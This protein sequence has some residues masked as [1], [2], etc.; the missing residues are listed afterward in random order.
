VGCPEALAKV[1]AALSALEEGA[2]LELVREALEAGCSALEVIEGG[3][4]PGMREV[5][6]KFERG[7][8]FLPELMISADIFTR[9]VSLLQPLLERGAAQAR[10]GRVVIGTVKGDIHDLGKNLVATML[11]VDGFEVID[12]GVDVPPEKFVEA[13]E[14]YEPD[15][16]G[17][18]AL[19]TTTMIEMRNVID[20]L[21][22]AGLRDRVRVI[23]GGAPVTEEFAREVGADAYAKDAVEAV[24][25][26][27][28]L[29]SR[30]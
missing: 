28:K 25:K 5:G 27:R 22:S 17:M 29:V 15:I 6:E 20:A 16:V 12:L 3:L 21:K 2:V 9:A 30:T 11:R 4:T 23:V 24:E 8:Y 14:R 19:L 18:S 7:E 1:R 13:V 10:R 26:C